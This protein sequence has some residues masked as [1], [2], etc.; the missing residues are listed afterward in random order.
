MTIRFDPS[1][2]GHC[3][4][5]EDIDLREIGPLLIDRATNVEFS[6]AAQTWEVHDRSGEVLFSDPSRATCLEWE[7][8]N[9][10]A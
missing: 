6:E 5:T 4:Y 10:T 3:L 9:L 1:G 8:E 2:D 7:R